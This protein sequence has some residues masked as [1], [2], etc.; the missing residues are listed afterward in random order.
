MPLF[1]FFMS[2]VNRALSGVTR[3]NV[4][5]LVCEVVDGSDALVFVT[6]GRLR[7]Q[8][9]G[10]IAERVQ[11]GVSLCFPEILLFYSN[12]IGTYPVIAGWIVAMS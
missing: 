11:R 5:Q 2:R 3:C 9:A 4:Q 6:A 10:G 8:T 1:V 12:V 7:G